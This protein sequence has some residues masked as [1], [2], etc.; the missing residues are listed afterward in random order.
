MDADGSG[1]APSL[2]RWATIEPWAFPEWLALLEGGRWGCRWRGRVGLTLSG[3]SE[4]R[5][6]GSTR[7]KHL[8]DLDVSGAP[9]AANRDA[10]HRRIQMCGLRGVPLPEQRTGDRAAM[11]A[12]GPDLSGARLWLGSPSGQRHCANAEGT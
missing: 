7:I 4:A 9:T 1:S 6:G 2:S 8:V 10:P 5:R 3:P 12:H 11:P